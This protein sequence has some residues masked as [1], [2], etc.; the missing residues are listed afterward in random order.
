MRLTHPYADFKVHINGISYMIDSNNNL[1]R[2]ESGFS[3]SGFCNVGI[4]STFE[5][6]TAAPQSILGQPFLRSVYLYVP[7][8]IRHLCQLPRIS[9]SAYRYPTDSCPGYFGFAFPQGCQSNQAEISQK[10][11]ST[12]TQ[13]SRCLVFTPP[14]STPTI[15]RPPG[16]DAP[17]GSYPAFGQDDVWIPL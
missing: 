1:I 12:P 15:Q 13:S 9:F 8:E 10:P 4:V 17:K 6:I 2:P 11:T 14:T 16:P 5:E 3:P 7:F